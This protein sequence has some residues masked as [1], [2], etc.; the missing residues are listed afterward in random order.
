MQV[1]VSKL[2]EKSGKSLYKWACKQPE[3]QRQMMSI[4]SAKCSLVNA[5]VQSIAH[6]GLYGPCIAY[7]KQLKSGVVV[8]YVGLGTRYDF[9]TGS[10]AGIAGLVSRSGSMHW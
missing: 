2:D 9:S 6:K 4:C 10:G 5:S 8:G 1:K 7:V 3:V